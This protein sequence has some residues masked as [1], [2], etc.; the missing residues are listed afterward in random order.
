VDRR[1]AAREELA[2]E[3]DSRA[4]PSDSSRGTRNPKPSIGSRVRPASIADRC[5]DDRRVGDPLER[6][7]EVAVDAAQHVGRSVRGRGDHDARRRQREVAARAREVD[8]PARAVARDPRDARAE[9]G[10]L[11]E[12]LGEPARERTEAL[13]G[14]VRPAQPALGVAAQQSR[15]PAE[16]ERSEALLASRPSAAAPTAAPSCSSSP[17]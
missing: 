9:R 5:D 12:R 8:V 1:R 13:L 14:R 16:R 17:A 7:R 11:G 15:E 4:D 10:R 3:Q 6:R 2:H